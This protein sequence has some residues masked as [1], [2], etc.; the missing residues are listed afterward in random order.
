MKVLMLKSTPCFEKLF[1]IIFN[2]WSGVLEINDL[3]K[4]KISPKWESFESVQER[5]IK[6]IFQSQNL[7]KEVN[8]KRVE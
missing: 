4:Q 3:K 2:F 6:T 1:C 7:A 8:F 5:M